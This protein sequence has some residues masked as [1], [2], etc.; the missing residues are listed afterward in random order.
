MA[1]RLSE[2]DLAILIE[3]VRTLEN[4][5]LAAK[6][7]N[8]LGKPIEAGMNALPEQMSG[9]IIEVSRK[10]LMAALKISLKTINGKPAAANNAFHKFLAGA[11]GGFGGA[12]GLGALAVEL[13][14]STGIMMRSILDVARAY[15]E[16]LDDPLVQME[17][18]NVFALGGRTADDDQ[19]EVGYFAVRLALA[20]AVSEAAEYIAQKGVIQESAPAVVRLI[21]QIASRFGVV[22]SEKAA[23]MAVPILGAAGGATINVIFTDHFQNMARGHFTIRGLER[24]Y[25]P[26][27]VEEAY[28]EI[29]KKL[30]ARR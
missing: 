24:S 26:A 29:A 27:I 20:R 22:V 12:F 14:L 21:A 7:T 6:L 2:E 28:R 10:S 19:S 25:A 5:S 13:P 8:M 16:R 17:C 30:H 4:P 1:T 3:A 9:K 15:G 18:M 23:A 11:S